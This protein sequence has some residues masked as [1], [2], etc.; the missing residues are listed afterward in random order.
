M[1]IS[2]EAA[3]NSCVPQK[4]GNRQSK[5]NQLLATFILSTGDGE[6]FSKP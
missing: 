6:I 3:I 1:V 5:G 2:R 4:R